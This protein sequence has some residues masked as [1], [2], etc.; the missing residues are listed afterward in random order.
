MSNWTWTP[1]GDRRHLLVNGT[2]LCSTIGVPGDRSDLL[3]CPDC[4]RILIDMQKAAFP[5]DE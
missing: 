3:P 5:G 2:V 1:I 4:N